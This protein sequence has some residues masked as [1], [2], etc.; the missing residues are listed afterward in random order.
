MLHPLLE[1]VLTKLA[2]P[3]TCEALFDA[4]TDIVYFVKDQQG[5]YVLVNQTL[6]RR[7]EV[8]DKGAIIGK[9]AVELFPA[10]L[11]ENYLAQDLALIQTGQPLLNELELHTYPAGDSGWCITTKLPLRGRDGSCVGLM[12]ISRDLHAPTEDYR[13][14]AETLRKVQASL[15]TPATIE[16]VA[17]IAGLSTFQFDHRIREVFHLSASQ[18]ILKFRMD[19]ATQ[20]LRDTAEPIA[21]VALRCGY[22]D[23]SAFTRQFHRTIGLT[24]GEYRK[25]YAL[26]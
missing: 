7:C 6:T 20:R 14:V 5:R 13:D 16:E 3:L 2:E 15:D 9:T 12:G 17:K 23:Q 18:L 24:P 4:L 8:A 25:R 22:A 10:P 21:Q 26:P 1:A 19:R 11:G